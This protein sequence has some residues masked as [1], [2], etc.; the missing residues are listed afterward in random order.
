MTIEICG[1]QTSILLDTLFMDDKELSKEEL[2]KRIN[3]LQN[4]VDEDE[5]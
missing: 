3:L 1:L 2:Q 5:L 4:M